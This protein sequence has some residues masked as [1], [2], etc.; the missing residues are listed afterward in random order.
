MDVLTL[1]ITFLSVIIFFVIFPL[2]FSAIVFEYYRKH[3]NFPFIKNTNFSAIIL[4]NDPKDKGILAMCGVPFLIW[5][6]KLRKKRFKLFFVNNSKEFEKIAKNKYATSIFVFGHG[7]AYGVVL[8]DGFYRYKKLKNKILKKK[9]FIAQLHCNVLDDA[10][11]L[12]MGDD[13]SLGEFTTNS[14]IK[15][16]YRTNLSNCYWCIYFFLGGY[17]KFNF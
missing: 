8:M 9:Y 12:R 13:I 15:K 7:S 14:F 5:R 11:Y 3:N 6:L 17:K 4:T 1:I 16:G 10:K 2:L